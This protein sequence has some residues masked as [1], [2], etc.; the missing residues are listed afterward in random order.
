MTWEEE[1]F[2]YAMNGEGAVDHDGP[3]TE[4]QLEYLEA[5]VLEGRVNLTKQWE[6]HYYAVRDSLTFSG[7]AML[8]QTIKGFELE[9]VCPTQKEIG[10]ALERRVNRED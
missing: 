3:A 9:P 7:A 1:L 8:I 5:L 10:A 6:Q 2:E 4:A